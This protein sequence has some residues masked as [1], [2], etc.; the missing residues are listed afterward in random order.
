M[1][2]RQLHKILKQEK[3]TIEQ[4]AQDSG[5]GRTKLYELFKL[6]EI[7]G[8]DLFYLK[9]IEEAGVKLILSDQYEQARTNI[10]PNPDIILDAYNA[11]KETVSLANKVIE[12]LK[13]DNDEF[14]EL[15]KGAREAGVITF[16]EPKK[17]SA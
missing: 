3:R 9:M 14:R 5:V 16:G 15:V 1:T 6:A 10:L 17:K 7:K 2:G 12:A 8:D 11:M 13:A 4:I